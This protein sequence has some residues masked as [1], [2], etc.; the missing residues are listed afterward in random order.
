MQVDP[1]EYTDL[2]NQMPDVLA[3]LNAKLDAVVPYQTNETPGYDTCVTNAAWAQAHH[4][5]VGPLCTKSN[6]TSSVSPSMSAP[7]DSKP[8]TQ[9]EDTAAAL[10]EED[11]L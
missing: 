2:A 9:E 3:R 7:A 1:S 8:R 10:A 4:N 11:A 5:F 6:S